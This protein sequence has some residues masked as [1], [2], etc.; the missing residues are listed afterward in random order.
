M[1]LESITCESAPFGLRSAMALSATI[2]KATIH[3]SHIDSH[4]YEEVSLTIAKHPSETEARM[5]FRLVAYL[6]SFKDRLEFTKG[7]STTEEPDIWL[8][9]Y[10][11]DITEWIELGLPD[12]KRIKQALSRSGKVIV[13]TYQPNRKDEWTQKVASEF[14]KNQRFDF[15]HLIPT[16][17]N[18]LETLCER[19]MELSC[20]IEDN[21]MTLANAD[22]HAE[23][24]I[25]N[26]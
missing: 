16:S 19:G 6:Y 17:I 12:T 24:K 23:I 3:L 15:F 4:I 13:F 9:D 7:I 10:S 5:M 2:Y 8:K 1:E 21:V 25:E 26:S 14:S 11:G 22:Q 20:V 18:D